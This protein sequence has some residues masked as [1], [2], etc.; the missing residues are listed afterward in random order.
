MKQLLVLALSLCCITAMGQLKAK[1]KCPDLYVDVVNGTDAHAPWERWG[2][3]T[4]FSARP[5]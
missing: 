5:L 3:A 4:F 2:F 1:V